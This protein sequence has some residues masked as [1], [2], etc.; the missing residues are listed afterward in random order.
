MKSSYSIA[1]LAFAG[2]GA[3]S[4]G[5]GFFASDNNSLFLGSRDAG[6]SGNGLPFAVPASVVADLETAGSMKVKVVR[7]VTDWESGS[8]RLLISDETMSLAAG[9]I[10][11]NLDNMTITLNGETLN[12]VAG[13]A[14]ASNGQTAW[15][16]YVNTTGVVS[17]TG[18]VYSY[19][20]GA[21]PVLTNE[22]DT[23]AFFAFGYE[24][25]PDEIAALVGSVTYNGAFEGFGQ[26]LDPSSGAVVSSEEYYFGA[27]S[28]AADFGSNS[29]SGDLDGSFVY[30]GTVFSTSFAAPIEGNGFTG[31]MDSMTCTNAVCLSNSQIGG[32]FY[33]TDALESSGLL[34]MDVRVDP[35]SGAEYRF[36]AGGGYTATR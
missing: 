11:G 19:T 26:V 7:A 20:Y 31:S 24:T 6:A 22:F 33:G 15:A 8:T 18:S 32:A 29:V 10:A 23:E 17:G 36:I 30:D 35:N 9:D 4:A 27:I 21:T 13:A 14:P 1:I 28:L 12:F 25:D 5:T 16:N 34:G 2:L 3:C